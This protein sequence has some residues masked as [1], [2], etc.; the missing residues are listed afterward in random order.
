MENIRS[1]F[2]QLVK[3]IKDNSKIETVHFKWKPGMPVE[4]NA[5]GIAFLKKIIQ[6]TFNE[7]MPE[8]FIYGS[9]VC[10]NTHLCWRGEFNGETF[11]GETF[12]PSVT[13]LYA[14]LPGGL[15]IEKFHGFET[16]P[17]LKKISRIDYHREIGDIHG[18]YYDRTNSNMLFQY[19]WD[20][21][22]LNLSYAE[23]LDKLCEMRGIALWPFFFTTTTPDY[24]NQELLDKTQNALNY[25]F[26][27]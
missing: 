21:Y 10:N 26:G 15:Q 5:A 25:F 27:K 6:S 24:P 20:M 17:N 12:L 7:T 9:E 22:K 8:D 1:K 23:Y 11:W 18:T 2:D 3:E 16:N 14:E 4:K 13:D 19:K